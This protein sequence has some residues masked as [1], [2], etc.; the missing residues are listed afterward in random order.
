MTNAKSASPHYSDEGIRVTQAA[1]FVHPTSD[2]YIASVAAGQSLH[3]IITHPHRLSPGPISAVLPVSTMSPVRLPSPTRRDGWAA[4]PETKQVYSIA[5]I[6]ADGI[7]PE[8]VE[9]AITV[10]KAIAKKRGTF[11][12]DFTNFDWSSDTYKKTGRYVPDNHLD[13]LRKFDAIL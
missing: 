6:P 5:S 3:I 8:V 4:T 13:I 12:L 9:A 11:Q 7:G 10:L 2:G 1:G